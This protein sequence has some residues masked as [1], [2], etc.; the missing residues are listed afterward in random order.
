[1]V[2]GDGQQL[3]LIWRSSKICAGFR[4]LGADTVCTSGKLSVVNQRN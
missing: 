1:M 2:F 4:N 3:H